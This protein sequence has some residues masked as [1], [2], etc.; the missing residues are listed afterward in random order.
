MANCN[1]K[2]LQTISLI[3]MDKGM[4]GHEENTTSLCRLT[5]QISGHGVS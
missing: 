4:E 2:I 1:L 3:E 5:I